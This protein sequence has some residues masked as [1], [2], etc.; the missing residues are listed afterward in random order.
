[1]IQHLGKYKKVVWFN[2]KKNN[3]NGTHFKDSKVKMNRL[4]YSKSQS[5]T[6]I[7]NLDLEE[8]ELLKRMDKGTKYEVKRSLKEAEVDVKDISLDTFIEVYNRFVETKGLNKINRGMMNFEPAVI[9]RGAFISDALVAAHAYTYSKNL[10]I[11]RLLY[12]VTEPRMNDDADLRSKVGRTNR[13]LH[14][15]DMKYFKNIGFRTYDFGGFAKDTN[16]R[17]LQGINKFKQGFGGEVTQLENYKIGFQGFNLFKQGIKSILTKF[18]FFRLKLNLKKRIILDKRKGLDFETVI[19]NSVLKLD[20]SKVNRSSPSGN[21]YLKSVLSE[22]DIKMT[23]SILDI[24]CGKGSAMRLMLNYN[25]ARVDGIEISDIVSNIAANNF[26]LLKEIRSKVIREDAT[27]FEG[28]SN[29]NYFYFY[30]PFP[31]IVMNEVIGKL[32]NIALEKEITLIYNNP[33]CHQV[34]IKGDV[35]KEIANFTDKWGNGI[36]VYKSS[37]YKN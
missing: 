20:A 32:K 35:F 18:T 25:F 21:K 19:P 26:K 7:S 31:D 3:Y 27:K 29:Y 22:L 12:S 11:V 37:S 13:F 10:G 9:I 5:F 30:N 16:D 1:M 28:Y 23:D 14:F 4:L 24:G 34:V 8:D 2:T 17:G 33:V 36:K 15:D 6:L